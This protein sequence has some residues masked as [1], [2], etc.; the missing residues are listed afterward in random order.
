MTKKIKNQAAVLLGS[1]GGSRN[2]EAQQ[3]ARAANAK[4]ANEAKKEKKE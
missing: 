2:T 4:K 3:K 1:R